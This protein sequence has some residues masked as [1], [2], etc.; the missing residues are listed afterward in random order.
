MHD[1]QQQLSKEQAITASA[2]STNVIRLSQTDGAET[3]DVMQVVFTINETFDAL[4]SLL[5]AVETDDA[6]S[7]GS[8]VTV[9]SRSVLLAGLTKG[10]QFVLTLNDLTEE[11]IRGYYTV[12]GT[13]PTV[14]QITAELVAGGRFHTAS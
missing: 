10:A 3:G 6:S 5:I 9:D 7:F 13:N 14:G 2:A 4:T 1:S 11:Y 8:A 12:T